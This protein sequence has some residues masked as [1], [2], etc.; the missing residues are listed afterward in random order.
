EDIAYCVFHS[1][2]LSYKL[3]IDELEDITRK[4]YKTINIIGGGC[5]NL[6]LDEMIAKM[7]GMKV[8]AGPIE[9]TAIGNIVAQMIAF[10]EVKDIDEAREM[11][12]ESFDMKEF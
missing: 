6:L 11:I 1:L 7:T 2:A 3:A 5:Q 8:I 12:K 4:K 10:N 9:A